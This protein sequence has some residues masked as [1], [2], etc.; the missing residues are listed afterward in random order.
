MIQGKWKRTQR[1]AECYEGSA[2]SFIANRHDDRNIRIW[3]FPTSWVTVA[4]SQYLPIINVRVSARD[5]ITDTGRN[6]DFP[7]CGHV[8]IPPGDAHA[9]PGFPWSIGNSAKHRFAES[10]A[11]K[12]SR[13]PVSCMWPVCAIKWLNSLHLAPQVLP[14]YSFTSFLQTTVDKG[15]YIPF[16]ICILCYAAQFVKLKMMSTYDIHTTCTVAAVVALRM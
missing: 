14:Y 1:D 16:H 3:W 6:N 8:L 2:S 15:S 7:A 10:R 12:R 11:V 4:T 9:S 13:H 5:E